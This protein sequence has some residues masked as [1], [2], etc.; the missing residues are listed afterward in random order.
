MP[1]IRGIQDN[2]TKNRT[3]MP[4]AALHLKSRHYSNHQTSWPNLRAPS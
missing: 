4:I 3:L 1:T 2:H